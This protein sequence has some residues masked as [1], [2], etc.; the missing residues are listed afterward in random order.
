M[1]LT[2]WTLGT[3]AMAAVGAWAQHLD[4]A[5]SL[6][7]LSYGNYP[8]QDKSSGTVRLNVIDFAVAVDKLPYIQD[9]LYI[10]SLD[11][12]KPL[13][14][15]ADLTKTA[16]LKDQYGDLVYLYNAFAMN[17]HAD[18]AKVSSDQMQQGLLAAVTP[19]NSDTPDQGLIKLYAG[20]CSS[21]YISKA[22][23]SLQGQTLATVTATATGTSKSSLEK[24]ATSVECDNMN[25]APR[26]A[27]RD[28]INGITGSRIRV[29]GGPRDLCLGGCCISW[30]RNANF[31]RDNLV[32]AA[33]ECMNTCRSD[34][35]SCKAFGVELQGTILNQC[36]SNRPNGC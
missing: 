8:V 13:Q 32:S 14:I 10:L 29:S 15:L 19:P 33:N 4:Y 36:L 12:L 23:L 26:A 1:Q 28:L 16:A 5:A 24:R 11:N 17:G 27:C 25:A 21:P 35:V 20:T 30:S 9:D 3:S 31:D 2:S 22:F 7:A 6:Q 34:P 18:H